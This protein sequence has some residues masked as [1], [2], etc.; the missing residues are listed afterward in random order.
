MV[1]EAVWL[2]G[3]EGDKVVPQTEPQASGAILSFFN[4]LLASVNLCIEAILD[5]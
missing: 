5:S 2:Q 3:V 1:W 4:L